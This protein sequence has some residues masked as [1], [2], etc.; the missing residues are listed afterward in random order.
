MDTGLSPGYIRQT[1]DGTLFPHHMVCPV[2]IDLGVTPGVEPDITLK[3]A[4]TLGVIA[5]WAAFLAV[6]KPFFPSAIHFGLAEVHTVDPA[7][8]LDTFIF[9]WNA[10]VVG[11]SGGASVVAGQEIL[12]FKTSIGSLYK[13]Y[14]MEPS[15]PVNLRV[16]PPYTD[17]ASLAL[18]NFV[19]SGASPV[20]G[21]KN[22]YPFVPISL[23]TKTND[24]L[25]AQHGLA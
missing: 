21:R 24:K 7:T 8:G 5:A 11:V 20:Y 23:I 25:R 12:T 22:A 6:I 2:N 15:V 19:V 16:L 1:Y 4:S 18:S 14:L 17:P 10:G 13:L 3:D 9:A